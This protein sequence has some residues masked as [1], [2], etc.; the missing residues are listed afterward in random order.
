MA[1]TTQSTRQIV[2]APQAGQDLVVKAVPG[3]DIALAAA[4]DQ[5]EA[6]VDGSNVVFEFANGGQ[7]V[8][9]F[10]EIGDAQAPN[11][12]MSD[13]TILS[14]QEF[15]ASLGEGDVEPAAGPDA[16]AAGGGGV[17]SYEDDAGDIIGGVDKLGVL[18][19]RD[20]SSITVE[21]LEASDPA[22]EESALN[23][24]PS[25]SA[26]AGIVNEAGLESGTIAD[27]DAEFLT[28]SFTISDLDGLGDITTLSINGVAISIG[29]LVGSVVSTSL[30]ILTVTGFDA[31]TGVVSYSYQLAAPQDHSGGDVTDSFLVSVTD[32]T[33]ASASA[34]IV[35]SVLDDEP[36]A[37]I[38]INAEASVVLD[39]SI[40]QDET[41]PNAASDDVVTPN[42]FSAD[43]GTL[44]GLVS[45]VPVVTTDLTK[46]GADTLGATKVVTL[47]VDGGEG[48]DSG[49]K[50]TAGDT[51]NLWVEDDGT[52]T[53]RVGGETGTVVFA[54]TI[55]N[56]GNLSVAQYGSL[57]HG[58]IGSFDE[59]VSLAGK[60]IAT[61][62][63]T[64]GDGDVA[65]G[66]VS[67]GALIEFQDDGPS[68]TLAD[69][70]LP[71]LVLDESPM[72]QSDGI[73][74]ISADF[75]GSFD[76][77]YGSDGPGNTD[78]S[79]SLQGENLGS[80]MF[81]LGENGEQGEEIMLSLDGADI[82]G[83]IGEVAY[84]RITVDT[85]T[86]RVTFV[87]Y[88]NVWHSNPDNLD[89][90]SWLDAAAGTIVLTATVTDGDGDTSSATLDLSAGV[91]AIEDDGPSATLADTQ[92]PTLVLDESSIGQGEGSGV[93]ESP[94]DTANFDI[95]TAISLDGHF[96]LGTNSDVA[97]SE[98]TPYAS[99]HA[100]G[101][102]AFDYFS[103]TVTEAGSVGVF[104]V[105]YAMPGFDSTLRL[106][107]ANGTLLAEVDD[108][109]QS[110]GA[111]GSVHPYDA[112]LSYT[113]SQTGTYCIQVGRYWANPLPAGGTYQLQVSLT[114]A[115]TGS[116]DGIHTI[117]ADFA[118]S[119]DVLYGTDGPGDTDYS[120]SLQGENLGSGMFALGENGGQGEEIMLSLDG[121]DIVGSIGDVTFFR[122]T[123]DTET[124]RVTFVQY[125][126]V[127]HSNPDNPDDASWLDA[128]TGTIVLT[129]TATDGD[130]DTSS[131]TLDLSAGVFAIED[132]GPTAAVGLEY[133]EDQET[134][135]G[136][137]VDESA[138][139][140]DG[141]DP[142]S[143][144]TASAFVVNSAGSA[145]GADEE[146]GTTAFGLSL[147]VAGVDSGVDTTDGTSI[148]LFNNNGVIEGRVGGEGG[149]VAF[150]L[151]IDSATGEVTLTQFLSL[152]HPDDADHNDF[153]NLAEGVISAVVTVTDGDGDVDTDTVDI[154]GLFTF[155]DD[156]P[157][158]YDETS[159]TLDDEGLEHGVAGGLGDVPGEATSVEGILAHSFGA[160]GP[161]SISF[162]SMDGAT[163]TVGV[164][165]VTYSWD[166]GT[167]TLLATGARGPLFQ[168]EMLNPETGEYKV[169]LLDNVLHEAGGTL[170]VNAGNY[171]SLAGMVTVGVLVSGDPAASLINNGGAFGIQSA[172][173][174]G[175][176]G[177]FN[178][179]NYDLQGN[180]MA[181]EVM[182]FQLQGERVAS[183][184]VVDVTLFFGNETG[185]GNEVGSYELWLDGVKVQDA[186]AFTA[187]S[188]DGN[189]Q[190]AITG[191]EGGFD[192][193][194][195]AALPG[196]SPTGN[197]DSDYSIKQVA[198][199]LSYE[200]DAKVDLTYT[201]TD[202]DGDT[203][204]GTLHLVI[205][206]DMPLAVQHV[207]EGSIPVESFQAGNLEAGWVADPETGLFDPKVDHKFDQDLDGDY[208]KI[209]WGGDAVG[210]SKSSYEFLD[211]ENLQGTDPLDLGLG[212]FTVGTFV[213]NNFPIN[214]GT[215]IKTA[216]L[217]VSFDITIGDETVT[218]D[219]TIK[220]NHNETPNSPGPGDDIVTII[221]GTEEVEI[222]VDGLKYVLELGFKSGDDIV[223]EIYTTEGKSTSVP[224]VA[225]LKLSPD[226]LDL[227]GTVEVDYGA[228]GPG[229]LAWIGVDDDGFIDGAYGTLKVDDLGNY[230]YNLDDDVSVPEGAFE[231]FSYTATDA[232]G[233][234]ATSTLTVMLEY[235]GEH[236]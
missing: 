85:E 73:H 130:G 38:V 207:A 102:N 192:E 171:E 20:F 157:T 41:D 167:N 23:S 50:T 123:V 59:S 137:A 131:A 46:F 101:N 155:Y 118:G 140:D 112:F 8:L 196:T 163:G 212:T 146:G 135:L 106:Y 218:V 161:G 74:T 226:Y 191:P 94:Q 89:D 220:F 15:L 61:V 116:G 125:E 31:G 134:P 30:G 141:T 90:A 183:S 80:G 202:G 195:F 47:D 234:S 166:A 154:G 111:G 69:T 84:F 182:V 168:V 152:Q 12:V 158:G 45:G 206:D 62:T 105:D 215:S 138:D 164:E 27:S 165:T 124:G 233:D 108:Y 184:A 230:E 115:I 91:F 160:D 2:Q 159:A 5:A 88:E 227:D 32:A 81:A 172:V 98:T 129:A 99:V 109:S 40:G 75:A 173:D 57:Q 200:N 14:V 16:G 199:D 143:L 54:I 201:V 228:D 236:G 58:E 139:G 120:L 33:G 78:Y 216:H 119:F 21:G 6:K 19:P 198:F 204:E 126:N 28:G 52:V 83:S 180:P 187:N 86:G 7:V 145:Y 68:V 193:I 44:I 132:D 11:I 117:S 93:V 210:S 17:G 77:L 189:Y 64:D 148:L 225:E 229:S 1:E 92:L 142:V 95:S 76:V 128:A 18:N 71:S 178:E 205:N 87:Q 56:A 29:G 13:G 185:V 190:L 186:V 197:D 222:V 209:D 231:T 144:G 194:R 133:G 4:F 181:S 96:T 223:N 97:N 3:Q 100:A 26:P 156:G 170:A 188:G 162:A 10:S 55:N 24:P 121:A 43:F 104:D 127:W 221:D 70:Q 203:D 107:D 25:I 36:T 150:S 48:V 42:P 219:H 51:I 149:A 177:R 72:N 66:Q 82:V 63:V 79:L 37:S 122:I 235:K 151:G 9:D 110:A 213:H 211:N 153:V 65:T 103:F 175:N 67:I 113:F 224:L 169:S 214:T 208:Q 136:V 114:N 35:I 232:D 49:L 179:I 34:T 22:P 174:G 217:N 176:G 60:L 39:E 147:S 53:G